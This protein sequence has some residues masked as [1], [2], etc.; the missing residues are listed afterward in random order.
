M[1]RAEQNSHRILAYGQDVVLLKTRCMVLQHA[2]FGVDAADSLEKFQ[3]CIAQAKAPYRLFLLG[4]SIPDPD[5]VRIIASVA[6]STTLIYQVPELIPP[7]QLV[8]DLRE[9]LLGADKA[10][11]LSW[12]LCAM[13]GH[14]R[15]EKRRMVT[16]S[17]EAWL[18][19]ISAF[20]F[21]QPG[22]G[23]STIKKIQ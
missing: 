11:K 4:H 16:I 12:L 23:G 14:R 9:L 2:G 19:N 3:D 7:L 8:N 5:R 20:H 15:G 6:D 1:S 13:D 22:T 18:P 10:P 21:G 17:C